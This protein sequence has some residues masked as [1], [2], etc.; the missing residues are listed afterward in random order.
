MS[1]HYPPVGR[2]ELDIW[3]VNTERINYDEQEPRARDPKSP[4]AAIFREVPTTF[5]FSGTC[6]MGPKIEP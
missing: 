5:H 3:E 6:A 2:P 1:F 4:R